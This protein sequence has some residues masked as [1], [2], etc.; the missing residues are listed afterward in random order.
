MHPNRLLSVLSFAV[1]A[2]TASA[3]VVDINGGNSWSGWQ[4]VGD[5]Q[6]TSWVRGSTNRTFSMFS[7]YFVLDAQQGVGGVRLADN[8]AGNGVDYTWDTAASLFAGVL[9]R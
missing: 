3:Q 1:I 7:T 8:V 9:F 5:S 6:S 4:A 2:T